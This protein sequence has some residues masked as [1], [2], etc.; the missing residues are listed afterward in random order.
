MNGKQVIQPPQWVNKPDLQ[1]SNQMQ[2]EVVAISAVGQQ[3]ERETESSADLHL[4]RT[5]TSTSVDFTCSCDC[6]PLTKFFGL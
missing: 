2:Q 1:P 6:S 4:H 5:D 3:E